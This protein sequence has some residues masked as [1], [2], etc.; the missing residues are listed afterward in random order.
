MK[1]NLCLRGLPCPFFRKA[2]CFLPGIRNTL[3]LK[4]S[5][6]MMLTTIVLLSTSVPASANLSPRTAPLTPD[7]PHVTEGIQ[8]PQ[9]VSGKVTDLSGAPLPGVAVA[10]K[11]TSRGTATGADGNYSLAD[12]PA[13][14]VLQFSF[15]GMETQEIPV[16]GRNTVHVEMQEATVGIEE[17]VAIGYGT[18]KKAN[19]TGSIGVASA[20]RL[21]NRPIVSTG[22]GLQGVIPNLNITIRN[23]DPTTSA[24]YNIR[25]YE[26]ING[27]S[28]LILVDGVPMDLERI[29]PNDIASVTVLKDAASAAIYG[30]RA[31]FGVILVETKKGLTPKVNI[32]LDTELSLS[33]PIFL[34][35]PVTDPYTFVTAYN[36][37]YTR[38]NGYNY[39]DD[40]YL[41]GTRAWSENPTKEN[42]WGVVNGT[43]RYYG[44]NRYKD[45]VMR[46]FS[47]Q[48][49]Y[50]MT[51]SKSSEDASY[52]VSFGYLDKDGYIKMSSANEIFKRYNIL[53]KTDFKINDWLRV[54]EK[55]MFN[56]VHSDKPHF[57]NWDVNINAVTRANPIMP[58]E[59]PDLDYYVTDGDHDS[60]SQYIGMYLEG[61][62]WLP[63]L[64]DGGRTTFTTNDLWLNQGVTLTPLK[65]LSIRGDFSYNTY[66]KNYQDVAS[67]VEVVSTNLLNDIM[68]TNGFSSSDYIQNT[69]NYNQYY[70]LNAYAEYTLDKF[71]GHYL[72]IMAGFNQEWGRY[73]YVSAKAFTLLTPNITDLNA[74]S[75]NQETTG[76]KDHISLRSAFYRLNYICKDK[77][78]LE[79]NG[80]YDGTSR[81]PEEDR[82]GFFPSVSL[83]WR[84]SNEPFLEN[85]RGWLDNLK[86]RVSYGSLGN[87][88]VS[89]Y[90]PYITTMGSGMSSYMM[91]SGGKIPYVSAS[92]LVSPTLTW[93]TV[94][95]KNIGFDFTVFNQRLD[96]S[97]DT[98][99]RDTKDMLMD[100]EYPDLL[101]TDAPQENAADL[102]TKGWELSATWRDRIGQD[103]KYGL[104][105]A[106]SDNQTEI[107]KYENPTG[108]LSEY[109]VG[110]KTGEIWGYVTE[111]I[112]QTDEEVSSHADQSIL[113][114]NWEAGDIKYAD[115]NNDGFVNS[116]SGTLDDPGD[117]KIIGNS[118]PRYAFGISSDISY[119]N[120]SLNIFFQGLLKK[121]YLP[122]GTTNWVTFYPF[123]TNIIEKYYLTETWSEDNRDAYFAAPYI[124]ANNH[125]NTQDQSRYVQNAAYIRLKN[126]TLNYNI[127]TGLL[128][129][130][131]ISRAQVYFSGMNLWEYTKMH[132]PLDPEST[133]TLTQEYWQQRTFTLGVKISL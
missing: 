35:D 75:G 103:W 124:S 15:V 86:L 119:K 29:N 1:Q 120:W 44:Y 12:V 17:V 66:H 74:T 87:Q 2:E 22:Q 108:A 39:Y 61:T 101:G 53:A 79:S 131:G 51:I 40:D 21:E 133:T 105:L 97:F 114:T 36:N 96:V 4:I 38:T 99:I 125:K 56:A 71:S 77:Y 90:Y 112:F 33:K 32:T 30:A 9:S 110:M 11:G 89:S 26:S 46:D 126:L 60:Y 91:D 117:R 72:K 67:K 116:G 111:G 121:D 113:G 16:N 41:R 19:L 20:E 82:F 23:G 98:Y 127:P 6:V 57:Y 107:T 31:S 8:Q 43:L 130:I 5:S 122:S 42:E 106:L 28:P 3:L 52:Y 109:Y 37:A 129:K 70:V 55:I 118:T 81:F 80:R 63:Y 73:T 10:I 93:E 62:N 58:I 49:K 45:R 88:S 68:I 24:D 7:F 115:T 69:S 102:R 128:N 34:I 78:L 123:K 48:Q 65:G 18:Q 83:G 76:S 25:G 92:G 59:F 14:A 94:A 132:K 50:N 100:V 64:K 95:T 85:A 54:D 47:P 27:G 84:I 104:T 13:N